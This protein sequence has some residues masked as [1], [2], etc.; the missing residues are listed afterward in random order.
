MKI[1]LMFNDNT[2]LKIDA[3]KA[4]AYTLPQLQPWMDKNLTVL[5]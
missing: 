1:K 5:Q 2:A 3:H 4:N